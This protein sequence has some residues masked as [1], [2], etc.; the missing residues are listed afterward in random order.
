MNRWLLL[1]MGCM[2]LLP[3]WMLWQ[4]SKQQRVTEKTRK[5][6]EQALPFFDK[7]QSM[8]SGKQDSWIKRQQLRLSVQL[9]FELA[10]WQMVAMVML[11]LIILIIG[12]QYFEFWQSTV[13]SLALALVLLFLVP[14]V[15]LRRRQR[16]IVKQIPMFIDQMARALSTGKSVEGAVRGVVP[17]IQMPLRAVLDRVIRSTDLGVSFAEAIYQAAQLH[18]IKELGL[19]ALAIRISSNYGSSPQELLKSVVHMIR[20]QEQAQRELAAMTGET[21]ITAWVLS[22][23]PLLILG[24]MYVSNPGYLDM[25][26]NDASGEMIFKGALIMQATGVL[27]FWR[28]MK[29][30]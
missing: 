28:M 25:M 11:L 21:K 18:G 19:I 16:M 30:I 1:L 15:R 29:S 24:Y 2:L 5:N 12:S 23:T 8:M 13:L 20:Q 3:A 17:D 9:G 10:M 26:L 22:L 6:L 4:T 14:Y 27:I 7:N